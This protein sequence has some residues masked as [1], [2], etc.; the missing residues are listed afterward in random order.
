M[1][2][3]KAEEVVWEIEGPSKA[4][5]ARDCNS[6]SRVPGQ[7]PSHRLLCEWESQDVMTCLCVWAPGR[8]VQAKSPQNMLYVLVPRRA[9]SR[10]LGGWVRLMIP[11]SFLA[12]PSLF[13]V[14]NGNSMSRVSRPGQ[15]DSGRWPVLQ[16]SKTLHCFDCS[17]RR[18]RD[19]MHV[20]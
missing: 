13:G 3:C 9:Q 17:A 19:P 2:P 7:A 15:V 4:A 8:M 20:T 12:T 5:C 18:K 1:L 10:C 6:P 16:T 11:L 14:E